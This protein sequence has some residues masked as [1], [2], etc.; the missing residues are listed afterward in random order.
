[1]VIVVIEFE[2]AYDIIRREKIWSNLR[3]LKVPDYLK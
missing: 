2:K 3:R 1:M